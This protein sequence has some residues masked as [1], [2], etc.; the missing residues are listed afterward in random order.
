MTPSVNAAALNSCPTS[1]PDGIKCVG[2]A[3]FLSDA[4]AFGAWTA[5]SCKPAGNSTQCSPA[6]ADPTKEIQEKLDADCKTPPE[7]V[8]CMS[9][10][11]RLAAVKKQFSGQTGAALKDLQKIYEKY[12]FTVAY[13]PGDGAGWQRVVAS[14]AKGDPVQVDINVTGWAGY[15]SLVTGGG[16]HAVILEGVWSKDSA[17]APLAL[18]RDS[19][20]ET[21]IKLTPVAMV[22]STYLARN[23]GAIGLCP[24][25]P[26]A[27]VSRPCPAP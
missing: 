3:K 26:T 24:W 13:Y 27:P 20:D 19:N 2:T 23:G 8:H 1:G 9:L 11:M 16:A 15:G 6:V 5:T 14:V 25:S 10:R 12:G 17:S 7:S 4:A 18:L 21:S 22:K